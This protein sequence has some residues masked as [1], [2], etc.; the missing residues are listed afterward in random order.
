[1]MRP[2]EMMQQPGAPSQEEQVTEEVPAEMKYTREQVVEAITSTLTSR[3]FSFQIKQRDVEE[4][5]VETQWRDEVGFEGGSSGAYGTEDKYRSYVVVSYNFEQDRINVRRTA[6]AF[7]FYINE[8]RAINPRRYHRDE[9]MEIQKVV[10]ERL[11][12][13]KQAAE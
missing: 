7:D 5:E 2:P 6:Q 1:M 9:N 11:E 4:A 12:E 8:W 3:Q 10:M 13:M